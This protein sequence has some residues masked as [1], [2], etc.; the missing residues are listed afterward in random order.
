[1]STM[2][3]ETKRMCIGISPGA[4]ER[5][6]ACESAQVTAMTQYGVRVPDISIV[7]PKHV[8]AKTGSELYTNSI[9]L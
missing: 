3:T 7:A 1:M 6:A 2:A 8:A 9:K 4:P 5:G